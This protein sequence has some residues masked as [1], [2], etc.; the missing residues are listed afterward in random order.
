[1]L[2]RHLK[3]L[4][5]EYNQAEQRWKKHPSFEEAVS[6]LAWCKRARDR[7]D[8]GFDQAATEPM[9]CRVDVVAHYEKWEERVLVWRARFDTTRQCAP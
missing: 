7:F 1:M 4:D 3:N 9:I 8:E 5:S 2:R 6:N